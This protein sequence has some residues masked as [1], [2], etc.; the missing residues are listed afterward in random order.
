M[1]VGLEGGKKGKKK[2]YT[3]KKKL[4]H[5][6]KSTKL[7]TLK[8]YSLDKNG[9][10]VR[11]RKPCPACVAGTSFMAKHYD[12]WYC[13]KCHTTFKLDAATIKANL[14]ALKKKQSEKKVEVKAEAKDDG[15]GKKDAK[16]GK[17]K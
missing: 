16:K 13:G 10:I 1:T 2:N 4:K 8:L 6:H 7:S 3:T 14:E 5:R 9:A 12:R 17:K 15:K 11:T